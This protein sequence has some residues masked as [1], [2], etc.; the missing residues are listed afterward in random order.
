[1]R[2]AAEVVPARDRQTRVV[3][4]ESGGAEV[5]VGTVLREP[6]RIG[7]QKARMV[8][9][10]Q[11]SRVTVADAPGVDE[12]RSLP[13]VLLERGVKAQAVHTALSVRESLKCEV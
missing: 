10:E 5:L 13:V 7:P 12:I 2:P 9:L 4:L 11:L 1:R 6:R 3:E 8:V